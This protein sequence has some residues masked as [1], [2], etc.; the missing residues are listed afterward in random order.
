MFV[1]TDGVSYTRAVTP[2]FDANSDDIATT[3][4]MN[5][6]GVLVASQLPSASNGY[7]WYRK[8]ADGWI[9]QG[10]I[11]TVPTTEWVAVCVFPVQMKDTNFTITAQAITDST[12][13]TR[14]AGILTQNRKVTECRLYTTNIDGSNWDKGGTYFWRI[15]GMAA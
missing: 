8:Y 10:G 3:K 12:Q 2:A 1:D 4:W 9:Q 5:Q 14:P 7:T 6:H 15:E 13:T 11:L